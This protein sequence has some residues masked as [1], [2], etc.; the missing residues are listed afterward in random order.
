MTGEDLRGGKVNPIATRFRIIS[1][2]RLSVSAAS[3][4]AFME[5]GEQTRA[6]MLSHSALMSIFPLTVFRP[7]VGQKRSMHCCRRAFACLDANMYQR[8]FTRAVPQKEDSIATESGLARSCRHS[9]M[10][11][12]GIFHVHLTSCSYR[13]RQG[14]L[15]VP[16]I[17]RH[18]PQTA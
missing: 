10:A 13:K 17:L 12:P 18:L 5:Q 11:A 2:A 1:S 6:S 8:I 4:S 9:N 7:R 14:A 3:P 16:T 15:P